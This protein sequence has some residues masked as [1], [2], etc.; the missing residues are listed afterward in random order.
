MNKLFD[1]IRIG[2]VELKNRLVFP[3]MT[4]GFEERGAVTPKSIT[5]Y[6]TLA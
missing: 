3:P 6:E 4:T 1:P 5:F 2:D